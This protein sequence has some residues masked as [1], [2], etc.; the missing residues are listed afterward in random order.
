MEYLN[1]AIA[2]HPISDEL[3]CLRARLNFCLRAY[4][5]ARAD[6]EHALKLQPSNARAKEGIAQLDYVPN[7]YPMVT[8]EDVEDQF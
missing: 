2:E 7:R 1:K 3:Y 8:V 4:D 6:Y 5:A